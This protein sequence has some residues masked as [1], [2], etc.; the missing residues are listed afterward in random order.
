MESFPSAL[1]SPATVWCPADIERPEGVSYIDTS[2]EW[3]ELVIERG[4][5]EPVVVNYDVP[6]NPKYIGQPQTLAEGPASGT[7]IPRG[8]KR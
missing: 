7:P 2:Y 8:A 5:T 1:S 6:A 3:P 4:T